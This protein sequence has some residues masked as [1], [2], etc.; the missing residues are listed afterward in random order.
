MSIIDNDKRNLMKELF[1]LITEIKIVFYEILN[2]YSLQQFHFK[3]NFPIYN[4]ILQIDENKI[5]IE[6]EPE[7]LL[8]ELVSNLSAFNSILK[9]FNSNLLSKSNEYICV[10]YEKIRKEIDNMFF[11][12]INI[13]RLLMN[14]NRE[15]E[16]FCFENNVYFYLKEKELLIGKYFKKLKIKYIQKNK[17]NISKDN[18]IEIKIKVSNTF[19]ILIRFSSNI[20]SSFYLNDI[21][22]KINI[23]VKGLYEPDNEDIN[24]SRHNFQLFKDLTKIFNTQFKQIIKEM[25]SNNEG[26]ISFYKS[27]ILFLDYICDYD[28][29]FKVHCAKCHNKIRFISCDKFFSI[30]LLKIQKYDDNYIRI[31]INDIE[32][33][34]DVNNVNKIFHFFHIECINNI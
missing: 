28:K 32:K 27:F 19:I 20:S 21:E 3:E 1:E 24:N 25:N 17:T 13:N 12:D 4:K 8:S 11:G 16:A 2:L 34:N 14:I 7:K 29:I 15:N 5:N 31:L 23:I 18:Y 10:N 6:T 9:E 26:K 33:E 22:N 30:P